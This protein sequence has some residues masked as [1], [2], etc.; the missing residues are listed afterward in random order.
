MD[1]LWLVLLPLALGLFVG[2]VVVVLV[3]VAAERGSEAARLAGNVLPP[4]VAQVL[5]ALA[6][7][8]VVI[9]PS[10]TVRKASPAALSMGLV[11]ND[12]LVH[13]QLRDL[14]DGVRGSGEPVTTDL[15]LARGPFGDTQLHLRV[16][17]S[18]VGRRDILLVAEDHTE[19]HRLEEVRRDFLANVSHELK[20]PISAIGLLA[21]ALESASDEPEQVRRFAEQLTAESERLSR[22]TRD[23]IELSRLQATGSVTTARLVGVRDVVAAAVERNQVLADA[24]RIEIVARGGKKAFVYGDER[25]LVAAVDNLVSNA[26]RYSPGGSQVGIGVRRVEGVVEITV[27]DQGEG[28][29]AADLD[30]VFE[31]FFRVDDAR[32]RSTGGTGLGLSIVKHAVQNHGGDVRAWSSPG[33]GST[34]TIRLPEAEPA[35]AGSDA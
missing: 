31:R 26:V 35:T 14:V 9:D 8:A 16:T 28:I 25:L 22:I 24:N 23:I 32:S 29:P 4:G 19:S 20:T 27:T 5:E 30:R 34:F 13:A 2:A 21:E 10:N 7:A 33:H 18:R 11:R 15:D 1:S 6:S 17:V 3:H 12:A